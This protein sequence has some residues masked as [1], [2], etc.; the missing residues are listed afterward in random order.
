MSWLAALW[1][2]IRSFFARLTGQEVVRQ[3]T[4][5][6]GDDADLRQTTE[7]V[8]VKGGPLKPGRRRL[9]FRDVRLLPKRGPPRGATGSRRKARLFTA[10]EARRRFAGTL[11]TQNRAIADLLPDP[12]QLSRL[13]L[14]KLDDEAALAAALGLSVKG[15]RHLSIH[16]DADPIDHYVSFTLPKRHGGERLI[17]APKRKL[18]AV[19]RRL[20]SLLI[21]RLPLHDAAHGFRKGRSVKTGA[22]PHVGRAVV[23]HLDLK[24]FFHQV[25]WRRVRG[26]L[27]A[28]GYSYPVA[29]TLAVL[30]TAAP[31][32]PV[33]LG[34]GKRVFVP[35]GERVTVQGAPTSPGLCNAIAAKL[36]RRLSGLARKLGYQYTRYADDLSF[37]GDDPAAIHRLIA[38]ARRI[39]AEEGFPLNPEKTR[40]MRRG[41]HQ[42]VTGVTVNDTLGLSRQQRRLLRAAIHQGHDRSGQ[43]AWVGMLNPDQAK[44][45]RASPKRALDP[46]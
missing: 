32:Q 23:I 17:M 42:T 7:V 18:K 29:A 10:D 26:Y 44:K 5:I 36:D 24:D 4:R 28:M 3:I 19:L 45:L 20:D 43:L 1:A 41:N 35:V 8:R 25:T 9:I 12:A 27:L 33:D 14:P 40:V 34:E 6:A 11:R 37:S 39:A 2:S 38:S 30:T 16:R 15:L 13:G 31:R 22:A 46:E 21:Q